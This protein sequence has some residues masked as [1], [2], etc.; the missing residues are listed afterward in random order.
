MVLN[1]GGPLIEREIQKL[2]KRIPFLKETLGID[3]GFALPEPNQLKGL[4]ISLERQNYLES[5][6]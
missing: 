2:V 5:P 1:Q 4:R 6:A 3:V